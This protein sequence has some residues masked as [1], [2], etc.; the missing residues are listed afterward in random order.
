MSADN[1]NHA[2][3]NSDRKIIKNGAF[4]VEVLVN[5]KSGPLLVL[6]PS[7]G[8]DSEEFAPLADRM[9]RGGFRVLRPVPR[10]M[11]ATDG[12]ITNITMHDLARDVVAVIEAERA[13][14]A[15]V[16]GHA[17][18]TYL[19]RATAAMRPDLVSGVALLGAGHKGPAKPEIV[20]A[21][22]KSGDMSLPETE[23]LTYL[24]K[25]FFAPGNDPSIWLTGWHADV[26]TAC[27]AAFKTPQADYWESGGRPILDLIAASDPLRPRE[28]YE[29]IRGDLGPDRVSVVIVPN[30]SHALVLEQPD[31]VADALL[32]FARSA[33]P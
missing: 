28:S 17:F 33:Q 26:S 27:A 5:G 6:L 30:A 3:I 10:G 20:D 14:P 16:A 21:V 29:D 2:E 11:G 13:G 32:Q 12:P 8:R 19:A 15:V 23:R 18:G 25:V 24:R 1:T 22:L 4:S 31:L 7:W 9:R